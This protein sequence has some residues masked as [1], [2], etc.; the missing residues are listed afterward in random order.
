MGPRPGTVLALTR[1][2]L[3]TLVEVLLLALFAVTLLSAAVGVA[4]RLTDQLHGGA[5]HQ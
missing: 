5:P 3:S 1:R 2:M 4:D